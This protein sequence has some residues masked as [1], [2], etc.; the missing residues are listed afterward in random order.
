MLQISVPH[1]KPH[2]PLV[3]WKRSHFLQLAQKLYGY[4]WRQHWK[5]Q[6]SQAARLDAQDRR[7]QMAPSSPWVKCFCLPHPYQNSLFSLSC[8]TQCPCSAGNQNVLLVPSSVLK[9]KQLVEFRS[10]LYVHEC[11]RGVCPVFVFESLAHGAEMYRKRN[12]PV[13]KPENGSQFISPE[14]GGPML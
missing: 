9:D 1:T 6:H 7:L 13:L 8:M 14:L 11:F 12:T 5:M 2:Q 3:C 10:K 4:L